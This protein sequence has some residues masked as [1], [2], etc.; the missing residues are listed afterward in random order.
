MFRTAIYMVTIW[1]IQRSVTLVT[2]IGRNGV[3]LTKSLKRGMTTNPRRNAP[4]DPG[5]TSL[6]IQKRDEW[7]KTL[8]SAEKADVW[9]EH[10]AAIRHTAI[11]AEKN[12]QGIWTL[13]SDV[14]KRKRGLAKQNFSYRMWQI[15]LVVFF[16]YATLTVL[17]GAAT[18]LFALTSLCFLGF[19]SPTALGLRVSR[20]QLLYGRKI[21][22]LEFVK[23]FPKTLRTQDGSGGS[24]ST[25][26]D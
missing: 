16:L 20:G 26:N 12:G 24:V 8:T 1:P 11:E 2:S 4:T 7:W 25:E 19:V 6:D 22:Y 15:I 21:T 10:D 9:E 23:P 14:A 18:L 17:S 3:T 5:M 13:T